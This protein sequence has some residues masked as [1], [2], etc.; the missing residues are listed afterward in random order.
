[1]KKIFFRRYQTSLLFLL[2]VIF[3]SERTFA[4]A[5]DDVAGN[6]L[7]SKAG[8]GNASVYV[9]LTPQLLPGQNLV[10]DIANSIGCRNTKT[11][12]RD[13][14]VSLL[15]GSTYSGVLTNFTG[16]LNYYGVSHP[17][18]L[19]APTAEQLFVNSANEGWKVRLFLTPISVASGML[20]NPGDLIATLVMFQR[21]AN[22]GTVNDDEATATFTWNIYALNSVVMPTGGCTV[23]AKNVTVTLPDYPG[24]ANVPVSINCEKEERL[25][26]FLSG[27]TVD[28]GKTIF[29]NQ[30][31][32][33]PAQ[34]VG[35]Q[36]KRNNSVIPTNTDV[37]LGTVGT[38]TV[39]LG[40]TATYAR[41][42]GQVTAGNVQSII[43]L[44]FEY[45]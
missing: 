26:F 13:D 18:P 33:S 25:K 40:L 31:S 28:T 35:V 8:F 43:D 23:T 7:D 32:V 20:I 38:S 36:L 14:Y 21:G 41:S 24:T 10:V 6:S 15:S 3:Y 5:C 22:K 45:Q 17:F 11:A 1:M 44:T 37:S 29:L 42:T 27:T 4:F 34:G 9:N 39:D 2:S 16:S 12:T 19:A 30:A